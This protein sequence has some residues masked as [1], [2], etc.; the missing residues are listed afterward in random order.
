VPPSARR[1]EGPDAQLPP[2][3]LELGVR[4]LAIRAHGE[5][6]LARKLA[7]RGCAIEDIESALERL[8]VLGH[9]DD[10]AFARAL[11]A[12]RAAGRGPALIAAELAAKGIDRETAAA[13]LDLSDRATHRAAAS[14]LAAR[15]T[16]QP[17]ERV[18]AR[19]HRRGFSAEVIHATLEAGQARYP[20][21]E[22]GG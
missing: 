18:A 4:L 5:V 14:R 10:V 8:R 2:D 19:L 16:A 3:A 11:A 22:P 9:L 20:R 15:W 13:A 6:E 12:R 7:R 21:A 1:R 17:P